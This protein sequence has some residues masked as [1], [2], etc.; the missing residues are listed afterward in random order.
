MREVFACL[1]ES[2]IDRTKIVFQA[3]QNFQLK[4]AEFARTNGYN[5]FYSIFYMN[6]RKS[7]CDVNVA[8]MEV[9]IACSQALG[10][11]VRKP[12][13]STMITVCLPQIEGSSARSL[14]LK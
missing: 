10:L 14:D 2:S 6:F 4:A 11:Y 5:Y 8:D 7:F 12:W 13:F 1:A 9:T 3:G